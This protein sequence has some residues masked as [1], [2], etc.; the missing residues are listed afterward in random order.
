MVLSLALALVWRGNRTGNIKPAVRQW[1]DLWSGATQ[2]KLWQLLT[3]GDVSN[4]IPNGGICVLQLQRGLPVAEQHLGGCVAG[5]PPLFELLHTHTTCKGLN[6]QLLWGWKQDYAASH[7]CMKTLPMMTSS[8]SL[9]TVL[10]T[11]VTLSFLASTYLTRQK[12]SYRLGLLWPKRDH[13]PVK[14]AP[15]TWTHH[16]CS[17]PRPSARPPCPLPGT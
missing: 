16:L 9:N 4:V 3:K 12:V 13:N 10:N 6:K 14:T 15:R 8:S 2:T 7:T 11:T 5:S 17:G 1:T